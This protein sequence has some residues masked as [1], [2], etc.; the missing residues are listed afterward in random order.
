MLLS[1]GN[2]LK[3]FFRGMVVL[4][5]VCAALVAWGIWDTIE[6][7]NKLKAAVAYSRA[8]AK[9]TI[10][11]TVRSKVGGFRGVVM[12]VGCGYGCNYSVRFPV[13]SMEPQWVAEYEIEAIP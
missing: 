5:L 8:H 13:A 12:S 6:H 3:W 7:G 11:Q 1:G 10:G 4:G 2:D 9:F